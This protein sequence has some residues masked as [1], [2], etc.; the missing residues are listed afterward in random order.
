M[1]RNEDH[2]WYFLKLDSSTHD[3]GLGGRRGITQNSKIE[4]PIQWHLILDV[5]INNLNV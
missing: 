2:F 4:I 5:M 3:R 1:V